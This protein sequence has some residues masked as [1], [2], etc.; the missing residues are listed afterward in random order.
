ML[1]IPTDLDR[2]HPNEITG[3]LNSVADDETVTA[4][5]WSAAQRAVAVAL[6]VPEASL[7]PAGQE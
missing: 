1:K 2:L 6:G 4:Q 3:W 7:A 5:E